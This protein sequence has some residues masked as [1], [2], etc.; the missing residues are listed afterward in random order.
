MQTLV[1]VSRVFMWIVLAIS[2]FFQIG[3]M[4]TIRNF[5]A[6][7]GVTSSYEI[8]FMLVCTILLPITVILFEVLRRGKLFPFIAA[9]LLGVCF[10]CIAHSLQV[11]YGAVAGTE[12]AGEYLTVWEALYRHA[13]PVLIPLLMIPLY[14]DYR[15]E[16]R[17]AILAAEQEEVPSILGNIGD[18]KLSSLAD[19]E[20]PAKQRKHKQ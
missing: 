19:E 10:V 1:P 15:I 7:I 3:T 12:A 9:A 16:R 14:I 4:I 2:L 6:S 20:P 11:Y 5:D 17:A 18:F 8:G 13:L